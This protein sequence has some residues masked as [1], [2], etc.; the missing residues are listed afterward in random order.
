[1]SDYPFF[2]P[3]IYVTLPVS[4]FYSKFIIFCCFFVC[5]KAEYVIYKLKEMEKIA[6]KDILQVCETFDRLDTGNCG[7]I[8]LAD[9][10]SS[11]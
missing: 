9:L 3:V 10:V 7:K 5:S 11:H 4:V 1:M 6:E 8:T 2:S